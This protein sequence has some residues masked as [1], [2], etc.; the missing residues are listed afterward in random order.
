MD[1]FIQIAIAFTGLTAL[2][3]TQL[4]VPEH[5]RKF[6]PV[7]GMVGQPFWIISTIQSGQFGILILCCCYAVLWILGFYNQWIANDRAG[8]KDFCQ[9]LQSA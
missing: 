4:K 7:F 2:A 1:F 3:L 9:R 5:W 6:A 8:F